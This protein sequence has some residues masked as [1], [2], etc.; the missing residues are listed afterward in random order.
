[1][2]RA[3]LLSVPVVLHRC[4][5]RDIQWA[6]PRCALGNVVRNLVRHSLLSSGGGVF[7]LALWRRGHPFRDHNWRRFHLRDHALH[8]AGVHREILVRPSVGGG[9]RSEGAREPPGRVVPLGGRGGQDPKH[10]VRGRGGAACAVA[11]GA[12]V[13]RLARPPRGGER[14]A[15]ERD[16]QARAPA[17]ALLHLHALP[18]GVV[19]RLQRRL[20]GGAEGPDGSPGH[21]RRAERVQLL[22]L[23]RED[24]PV[25]R[26]LCVRRGRGRRELLRVLRRPVPRLVLLLLLLQGDVRARQR[27]VRLCG[28]AVCAPGPGVDA[29]RGESDRLVLPVGPRSYLERA[30]VV[31]KGHLDHLLVQAA[32]RELRGLGA[33]HGS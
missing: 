13:R 21:I 14:R 2:V 32:E 22:R 12:A 16:T 20:P 1:M 11:G 27:L 23:G 29:A 4:L 3:R 15:A 19:P 9:G 31:P 7:L 33:L 26:R 10:A 28:A 8:T 24:G 6:V 17:A 30:S 5:H 25:V 18:V